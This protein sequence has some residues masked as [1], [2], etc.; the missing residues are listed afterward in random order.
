MGGLAK[1]SGVG[2]PRCLR[3]QIPCRK[4]YWSLASRLAKDTPERV[5]AAGVYSP[6]TPGVRGIART[7]PGKADGL[8]PARGIPRHA[9]RVYAPDPGPSGSPGGGVVPPAT[10]RASVRERLV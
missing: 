3:I 2:P 10:R 9:G 5:F 4:T 1:G 6:V 7:G 8:Y